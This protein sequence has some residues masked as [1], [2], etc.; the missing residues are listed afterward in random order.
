[1]DI[2]DRIFTYCDPCDDYND[3]A[4]IGLD[5]TDRDLVEARCSV[6]RE[7]HWVRVA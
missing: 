1:V 6:C 2:E 7:E 5:H 4:V 3:H